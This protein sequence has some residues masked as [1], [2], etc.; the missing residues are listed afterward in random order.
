MVAALGVEPKLSP[1]KEAILPLNDTATKL[2][3]EGVN[4]TLVVGTKIQRPAIE[5]PRDSA[6]GRN[7]TPVVSGRN[8][9]H[10]SA[11]PQAHGDCGARS[12]SR[13]KLTC[14]I[15]TVPCRWVKRATFGTGV[16]DR[17][18]L[19]LFVGQRLSAR[20]RP[21]HILAVGAG[22]EPA[23]GLGNSQ[24]PCHLATPQNLV[25]DL[26]FEPRFSWSQA[27]RVKPFP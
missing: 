8:G 27:K 23:H 17:T 13:T 3:R 10:K 9:A 1:Y 11:L 5:R 6:P 14:V 25:G 7:R 4:R 19:H 16:E 21:R 24:L 22:F 12:W 15:S 18:L 2:G 26:G 20:K